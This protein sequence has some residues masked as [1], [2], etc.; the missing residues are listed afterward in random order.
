MP[1]LFGDDSPEDI[2]AERPRDPN[3]PMKGESLNGIA[4]QTHSAMKT[5]HAIQVRMSG[6]TWGEVARVAGYSSAADAQKAVTRARDRA[7]RALGEALDTYRA[8]HGMRLESLLTAVWPYAMAGSLEH[9]EQARK[10]LG[11]LAKLYGTNKPIDLTLVTNEFLD[12]AIAQLSAGFP[13]GE[14]PAI[15]AP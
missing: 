11:D 12:A 13:G 7:N 14:Q 1:G 4:T 5:T 6:A 3:Y 8:L 10:L 15:E 2:E 9:N